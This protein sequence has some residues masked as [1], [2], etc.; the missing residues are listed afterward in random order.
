MTDLPPI[1][2]VIV[3][4]GS[5]LLLEHCLSAL[6][7]GFDVVIVDNSSSEEV[8]AL[9]KRHSCRY[10]DPGTNIGFAAGINR[11]LGELGTNQGDVLLLNPDARIASDVVR[12]LQEELRSTG[13]DRVACVAPSL[14]DDDGVPG[15]VEWPFTSPLR[16]WIEA[17]GLGSLGPRH[18]FLIGA[19]L[20]VR[21]EAIA[22]IGGFDERYFL[23]YEE[24]DWQWRA[25]RAGWSVMFCPNLSGAHKGAGTSSDK[26]RREALFE[27]S[28]ERYIR[29]WHGDFGW[30]IFRA[31][32]LFG[33]GARAVIGPNRSLHRGRFSRYLHGP[34]NQATSI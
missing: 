22:S 32:V 10:I 2:V 21:C 29:K 3:A 25:T 16:A 5:A 1:R 15:R 14:C 6:G 9:A 23:Y 18:G 24:A 12:R 4:Y 28:V 26:D 27:A 19:V 17:I 31:G 20:L 33:A 34:L 11:A 7:D 30:W 13:N 8:S